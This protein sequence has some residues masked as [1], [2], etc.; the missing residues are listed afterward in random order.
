[1]KVARRMGA[2]VVVALLTT[3]AAAAAAS[4]FRSGALYTGKTCQSTGVQGTT[5]VYK[6]RAS[7]NGTTLRFVGMT[8]ITGW[9]C[10]GGGGEA[11]LGGRHDG[12][13]PLPLVK[14]KPTGSLYGSA[15]NGPD[16]VSVTGH[17]AGSG[18]TAVVTFHLTNV[19]CHTAPVTLTAH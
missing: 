8:V 5:C 2:I 7:E 6:F 13:D 1:V 10:N 18:K 15:G 9:G 19:G 14:V 12:A 17:V 11:L 3:A 16:Q 4:H